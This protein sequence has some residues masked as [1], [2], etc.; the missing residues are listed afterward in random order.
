MSGEQG[1]AQPRRDGGDSHGNGEGSGDP[2]R[3]RRGRRGGRRNR[4]DGNGNGDYAATPGS[5]RSIQRPDHG[6]QYRSFGRRRARHSSRTSTPEVARMRRQEASP[7]RRHRNPLP[8]RSSQPCRAAAAALRCRATAPPLHR[9]R[10]RADVRRQRA[11]PAVPIP[12]PQPTR[13]LRPSSTPRF[14][15]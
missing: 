12:A 7:R 13:R 14:R 10:T 3:R 4:R 1:F 6:E 15:R 8:Q 9:A 11:L 5:A 2:R